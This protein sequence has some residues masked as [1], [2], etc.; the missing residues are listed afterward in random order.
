MRR[1]TV[2]RATYRVQLHAGFTF[3]DTAAIL[4]YLRE[5]GISHLFCS[6]VLQ[7]AP[8][9][10]HGYDVIDHSRV[11]TELGGEAGWVRLTDAVREHGMGV[12][13]DIVPN[14][15]AIGEGNRWWWD[16]LARGQGSEFASFFDIEWDPPEARLRDVILLPVLPDH[17]GRVLEAGDIR[18][19]ERQGEPVVVA[20]DRTFPL[21]PETIAGGVSIDALNADVDALDALL[22]R[23]HY[24]LAHWRTAA[25]D[26]GYRRF[27]DIDDLAGLRIEDDRVFDATHALPLRWVAEG[28]VDG[29]RI[30]HPDGLRDPAGYFRRLRA[31]APDAWIVA[32]KILELDEELPSDWPIDG[33]TGYGFA[34]L[35]TGLQVSAA[36]EAP[37]T[38]LW[39]RLAD[40]G[41]GWDEVV[42]EARAEVLSTV[43]GSDVNRLTDLFLAVCESHRRY[44]DFTRHEL[45]HALRA[46]AGSLPV[47]R[48]YVRAEDGY[49]ADRD[50]ALITATV[51]RAAGRRPDLEPEL[52]ELLGRILRLEL[53][54][55]LAAELA[56]RFQQLTPP[57]MA[58]GVEDTSFYRHHRLV[59]LNEVGGDP[60]RFGIGVDAFHASQATAAAAWPAAGLVLSTHDTKRSADVRARLATVTAD[61]AGWRELVERWMELTARHRAH[62]EQPT[63]ADAYLLLQVLVGAWPIDADRA[64]AYMAKATHEAK[65]RTTWTSPDA[66]YDTA[67][68]RFVRDS[69]ADPSVSAAIGA[70]V[71]GLVEP[72]WRAAL[73]QVALQLTVPGVPDIYQGG[74]VW[75]L[76]LVDPDNRR[77]VDYGIRRRLLAEAGEIGAA[78]AWARRDEG[79]PKLWLH[80]HLLEM[81]ARR[82]DDLAPGASYEPIPAPAGVVAHL[83]GSGVIVVVP[84]VAAGP[85]PDEAL[86]LPDASWTGLDGASHGGSVRIGDL[87]DA[88]PVAVLERAT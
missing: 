59:A 75:D 54:G 7:A 28:R 50:A 66:D 20:A 1:H 25:R 42:E 37:M 34:N 3:D 9:S 13:L 73:A 65:L 19:E 47:Y 41:P 56:M 18:L 38:E 86:T 80:R 52:F 71:D 69:L 63:D 85:D 27:F 43:L 15:M 46:V 44:R 11:S 22:N 36:A 17:Y 40:A 88:F 83:R 87:L 48:T 84:Q 68:E 6:P 14:H 45:H 53:S 61:P 8:G 57:A 39:E 74:E 23:Q 49:V 12:V 5:L 10:T 78:E 77:P 72:G 32:E 31:A 82:P 81:R 60:G 62:D 67:V 21:A 4:P 64:A 26:L 79:M 29:L 30:D 16:V 76:S 70:F 2:P 35:A 55:E 58:K 24:R 33:T 51:E